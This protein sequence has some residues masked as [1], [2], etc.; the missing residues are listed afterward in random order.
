M[1]AAPPSGLAALGATSV[2][3][4][5]KGLGL[6]AQLATLVLVTQALGAPGFGIYTLLLSV[7]G[8]A[9]QLADFGVGRYQFRLAHR[10]VPLPR[11]AMAG[12]AFRLAATLLLLPPVL[13]YAQA[14]ALPLTPAALAFASNILFQLATLN[15][16]QLLLHDRVAPAI[17]IESLPAI[18]Y[19]GL[20]LGWMVLA[21]SLAVGPALWLFLLANIV[22]FVVSTVAAGTAA[23]WIAGARALRHRRPGRSLAETTTL[24][25]R[26]SPIG[27]ELF[28]SVAAFN[29]PVLL[30]AHF[31]GGEAIAQVALYQ[32]VLGLEVALL[33]VA[34]AA[35]LK[36]YYDEASTRRL[37]LRPGWS[38]A[39]LVFALNAGGL[40]LL[41]PLAR[42]SGTE[43]TTIVMLAQ[44]LRPQCW[45]LASVTALIAVYVH[46]SIAA[47]GGN[48]L[49]QRCRSGATG[50]LTTVAMAALLAAVGV[51]GLNMVLLASLAGQLAAIGVLLA[52]VARAGARIR[53]PGLAF[54]HATVTG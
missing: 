28:L 1:S 2:R 21:G 47:L 52:G 42:W 32:R 36:T 7:G 38:A 5:A 24:A 33:S 14:T 49:W 44:A 50:I 53:L 20:L 30:A 13:I 54:R 48:W 40:L 16:S 4:A 51:A 46:C 15:R 34:V 23:G 39:I 45:L 19:C 18:H 43:D 22:G 29:L 27:I 35:R 26:A 31:G 6:A 17:L 11:L 25:R 41:A 37:D 12:L 8:I 10:G 9:G 3:F